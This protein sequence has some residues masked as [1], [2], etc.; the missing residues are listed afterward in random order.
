LLTAVDNSVFFNEPA[1]EKTKMVFWGGLLGQIV[2]SLLVAYFIWSSFKNQISLE[3]RIQDRTK[4][5]DDERK[6]TQSLL[7]NAAQGFLSF[8]SSGLINE[9]Y[10]K[11]CVEM[12][13]L[14]PAGQKISQCLKQDEATFDELMPMLFDEVIEF[15][16]IA[17]LFPK[18]IL[19][20]Q[21]TVAIELKP[22]RFENKKIEK[23]MCILS[24]LT[25]LK[26][27]EATQ[28][29]ERHLHECLV[30]IMKSPDDVHASFNMIEELVESRNEISVVKRVLH[31]M[32]GNFAFLGLI[33]LAEK[34]HQFEDQIKISAQPDQ[35]ISMADLIKKDLNAF[36]DKYN[37][38]LK[39]QKNSKKISVEIQKLESILTRIEQKVPHEY[40]F[41]D[42]T[43]LKQQ[44]LNEVLS[45]INEV[46]TTAADLLNKKVEPVQFVRSIYLDSAL[47]ASLFKSFI[48]VARNT[49]DHGIESNEDKELAGKNE[50][51]RLIIDSWE[52]NGQYGISFK[53]NGLGIDLEKVRDKA[54]SKNLKITNT[55]ADSYL[56]FEAGLSTK[57]IVNETSG[58]GIGLD[59]V[60][61]EAQKL[62][63]SVHII[64]KPGVGLEIQITF[65][66]LNSPMTKASV[67]A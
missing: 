16:S 1:V 23:I 32:K 9:T 34:C 60:R 64:N 28:L 49:A 53:D 67:S 43:V 36:I 19:I 6:N 14:V 11:I 47:Y 45:W 24:D 41:Q 61:S 5:L 22:L 38:I 13:G 29:K 17:A 4:D 2:I 59:A 12:L 52:T 54:R 18:E 39:I 20:H 55:E 58:R 63:G 3:Q 25:E 35:I 8:N 66:K 27:I 46:F 37:N 65:N 15:E 30:K 50:P 33:D 40:L 31:T 42:V 7:D 57:E 62:G 56:I 44:P 21:R 48:H 51:G 26:K 10:S